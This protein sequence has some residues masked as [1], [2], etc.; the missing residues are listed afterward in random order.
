[1][2]RVSLANVKT[3]TLLATRKQ[4]LIG[5]PALD[6]LAVVIEGNTRWQIHPS[7]QP[8]CFW[9]TIQNLRTGAFLAQAADGSIVPSMGALHANDHT[10][11]WRFIMLGKDPRY[12]IINRSTGFVLDHHARANSGVSIVAEDDDRSDVNH[13]WI[14][15]SVGDSVVG[16]VNVGSNC[17]LDHWGGKEIQAY[18]PGTDNENRQWVIMPVRIIRVIQ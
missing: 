17:A 10:V 18:S 14:L 16:I 7:P 9:V 15:E 2:L 8:P 3:N 1:M 11:Q 4:Q 6:T 5:G 12:A 13:Q